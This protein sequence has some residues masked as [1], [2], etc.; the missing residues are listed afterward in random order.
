MVCLCERY[1]KL[2]SYTQRKYIR[3][4]NHIIWQHVK[5]KMSIFVK[6]QNHSTISNLY[7][8]A[9]LKKTI[10]LYYLTYSLSIYNQE[11]EN[12][13]LKYNSAVRPYIVL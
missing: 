10:I 11:K 12:F 13:T 8:S 5:T 6:E 4:N 2:Q 7:P 1:S 9:A 3:K